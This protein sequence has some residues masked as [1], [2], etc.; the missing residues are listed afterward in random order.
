MNIV[1]AAFYTPGIR[2]IEYLIQRGFRPQQIR[3]ITHPLP[4]NETLL[5]FAASNKI[6]AGVASIRSDESLAWIREFKPDVLFSLYFRDIIPKTILDIPALGALN[7]HPSLLPKYRGA[8]SAPHVILNGERMTGFTYHYMTPEVDAGNIILQERVG[9][10]P[11]DT[12]YSLYHRLIAE[13]TAAFDKAFRLVVEG[14]APG[15]KQAG[16]PSYYPREVPNNGYIDPS[17]SR[18]KID[19]FIRAMYFPPFRG[20]LAKLA[21]GDEREVCSLAEYDALLAE[22]RVIA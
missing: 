16:K 19:R 13:G 3:L 9:I 2:V 5:A 14:R 1:V 10:F 7:L 20:A 6:E 11:D 4:R 21:G 12:A 22:G 18:E 8:F 17:W 15:R